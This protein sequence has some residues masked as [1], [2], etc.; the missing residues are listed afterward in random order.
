MHKK[1]GKQGEAP[2]TLGM[3]REVF[4]PQSPSLGP[5]EAGSH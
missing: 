3:T 2:E 1:P 5:E 4:V